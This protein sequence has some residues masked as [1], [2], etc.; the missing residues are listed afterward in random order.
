MNSD[1]LNVCKLNKI[2]VISKL[3]E[4]QTSVDNKSDVWLVRDNDNLFK[5]FKSFTDYSHL[6]GYL[7]EDQLEL[8]PLSFLPRYYGITILD[9]KY[10]R[11]SFVYGQLLSDYCYST[12]N[13]LPK[14]NV[15]SIISDLIMKLI[16]L[17][18]HLDILFL[19]L[20]PE[21]VL[22]SS[23]SVNLFD[24]GLSRRTLNDNYFRPVVSHPRFTVPEIVRDDIADS[25]SIVFQ[26]GLLLHELLYGRHPFDLEPNSNLDWNH[27]CVQYI[28]PYLKACELNVKD[29]RIKSMLSYSVKDRPTL[30]DCSREFSSTTKFFIQRKNSWK[31][32]SKSI[33]FPA[34]M[35]IPHKGH[36]K[37]MTT[38]LDMGF[39][40]I[41]SI[42]R[43]YT[44]TRKDPIPKWLVLQMI[45]RTLLE[46][47]YPEESF[48]F[49]LTPFYKT[50]K[51]LLMHFSMMPE[52]INFAASSNESIIKIFGEYTIQQKD[53]LGFE[54]QKYTDKSWGEIL[55]SAIDNNNY[56][57]FKEFAAIGV[58]KVLS[59]EKIKEYYH[60]SPEIHFIYSNN[61][62][63]NLYGLD[64]E[65]I[66]STKVSRYSTPE[67][68]LKDFPNK[69]YRDLKYEFNK[70][71]ISYQLSK[72]AL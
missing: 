14:D 19:D 44:L 40:L 32:N 13:L 10:I 68:C 45:S 15:F 18:K 67:K 58:E 26:V 23:N 29:E 46:L 39:K 50:D 28:Q 27:G 7:N 72:E 8:P 56:Q 35:G 62:F 49:Y 65:L 20:R 38:I 24:F 16:I 25:K 3:Q 1:F 17:Q 33:L 4:K 54:N 63:V 21:N 11:R 9:Q 42:Q 61:V 22:I 36:I 48:K 57:L 51:E 55:R 52:S 43:S 60:N 31:S 5:V 71:I 47:G 70:C 53:V 30:E 2:T 37:F 59:F 34:R 12:N 69:F 66:V 41:I 6:S 64:N